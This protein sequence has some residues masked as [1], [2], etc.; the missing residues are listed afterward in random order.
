VHRRSK[1]EKIM[2]KNMLYAPDIAF[3]LISIEKCD[4][5]GYK[6]TFASQKC[7]I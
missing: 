7:I 3:T 1:I 6:T 5:A 2:L 4:D